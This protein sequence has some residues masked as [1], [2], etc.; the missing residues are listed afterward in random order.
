MILQPQE[1]I[2]FGLKI[3]ADDIE[4]ENSI[5]DAENFYVKSVIGNNHYISLQG[6]LDP[7]TKAYVLVNGGT[8]N[9]LCFAGLKR[10]IANIAYAFLLRENVNA[11]RFGSIRKYDENSSNI[12][13][14]LLYNAAKHHFTIGKAYLT[15][16]TQELDGC[17]WKKANGCQFDEFNNLI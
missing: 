9:G 4:L 16:I 17:D 1:M 12:D 10:A 2:D 11:T 8:W 14:N 6:E 3:S 15:E 7:T 13:E 5:F